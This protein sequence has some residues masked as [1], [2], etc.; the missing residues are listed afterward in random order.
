[1]TKYHI[2]S[3]GVPAICRA[4][5]KPC[6]LG[7][8]TGAENHFDSLQEAENFVQKENEKEFGI[9]PKSET[10]LSSYA[11]KIKEITKNLKPTSFSIDSEDGLYFLVAKNS[12]TETVAYTF[13]DPS[14]AY[15]VMNELNSDIKK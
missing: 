1:M 7:G 11:S 13:D 10:Q 6:P 2:N 5:K 8:S 4:T 12:D 15:L 3:K 9:V 14:E